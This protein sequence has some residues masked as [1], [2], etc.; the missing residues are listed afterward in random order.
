MKLTTRQQQVIAFLR[1]YR[2]KHGVRPSYREIMDG[3]GLS[4]TAPVSYALTRLAAL[5]AIRLV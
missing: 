3:V 4:S 2:A 1:Q 5:G